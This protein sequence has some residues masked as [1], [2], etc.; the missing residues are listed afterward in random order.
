MGVKVVVRNHML[1]VGSQRLIKKEGFEA[2][3]V[4]VK[5]LDCPQFVKSEHCITI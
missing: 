5:S 4:K 2:R 3:H 1:D